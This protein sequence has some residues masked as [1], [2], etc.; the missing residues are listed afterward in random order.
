[1]NS[2]TIHTRALRTSVAPMID[3]TDPCFLR[4]LRLISPFGN[5]QLW[6][7]MVHANMFSRGQVHLDRPKLAQYV[8]VHELGDFAHG[9]VV[10]IGASDPQDAYA[11]VKELRRL[12]VRHVN[13]NCGCPSRN[14]QMG[15]FGAVLM[16]KPASAANIV[17]AMVDAATENADELNPATNISVK[18]RIGIDENESP[19]FLRQFMDSVFKAAGPVSFVLHARRAWLSG[20]SPEQN[21]SVPLLN[22]TRAYDMAREF[23]QT[24]V[25]VNGGV[26]S[27]EKTLAHLQHVDGVMIGRK[28]REDPWF[29]SALDQHVYGVRSEV[30]PTAEQVLSEYVQFADQM[31]S[32][33]AMRYTVLARP[34]Y[35]LF[36]GRKGRTFRRILGQTIL[37]AKASKDRPLYSIR[38]SEAVSNAIYTAEKEHQQNLGAPILEEETAVRKV[39]AAA[40]AAGAR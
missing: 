16:T 23:P 7:E 40:T 37:Q 18:C 26:D 27:V 8:P 4:L 30:L 3:V 32:D 36:S 33:Y 15:S 22:H 10:Q 35:A 25:F 1:M 20:L 38:F 34:L 28:I 21:R 24:Q 5:H 29:L 39:A 13:L 2:L 19:E 11:A 9:T 14:V 6:T 12:G 31:H 17:G